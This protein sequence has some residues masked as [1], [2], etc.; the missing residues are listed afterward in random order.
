L[1]TEKKAL[2]QKKQKEDKEIQ[3]IEEAG[4]VLDDQEE[5]KTIQFRKKST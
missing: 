4:E 1:K 3:A 5:M 2:E